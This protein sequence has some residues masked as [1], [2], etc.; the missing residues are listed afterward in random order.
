MISIA[1]KNVE[2]MIKQMNEVNESIHMYFVDNGLTLNYKKCKYLIINNEKQIKNNIVIGQNIIEKVDK[3]TYLGIVIDKKLRFNEMFSYVYGRAT[4]NLN[5]IRRNRKYLDEKTTF[6]LINAIVLSIINYGI[7][8]YYGFLNSHEKNK[9]DILFKNS[10]KA[11]NHD[12]PIIAV[13]KKYKILTVK[14]RYEYFS[15]TWIKNSI[16]MEKNLF[17]LN[18]NTFNLRRNNIIKSNTFKKTHGHKSIFGEGVRLYNA[19]PQHLI[20]I[21]NKNSFKKELKSYLFLSNKQNL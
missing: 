21:D 7:D 10:M 2:T 16:Q 11:I 14:Q 19:L 1:S 3:F 12:E 6:I 18:E 20:S 9:L 13:I 17:D 5:K 4:N 15:A 8:I